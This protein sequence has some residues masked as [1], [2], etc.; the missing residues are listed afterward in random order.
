ML[1][2]RVPVFARQVSSH[3]LTTQRLVRNFCAAPASG[4]APGVKEPDP[5][6][7]FDC[8]QINSHS[9]RLAGN[10]F[11]VAEVNELHHDDVLDSLYAINEA[12]EEDE[13]LALYLQDTSNKLADKQE[14]LNELYLQLEEDNEEC[15]IDEIAEDM[16]DLLIE[17]KEIHLLP[18]IVEDYGRIV[19]D[20]NDEVVATVN[21]AEPLTEQQESQVYAK[22]SEISTGKTVLM[23]TEV[24]PSLLGGMTITLGDQFQDL[25]VRAAL[26]AAE[27]ALRAQ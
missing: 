7:L 24:D 5:Q 27:S 21:T 19:L 6:E 8:L 9:G 16:V 1:G 23:N 26:T 22:L 15:Y 17:N 10:L 13:L 25:S 18:E 11:Q 3:L 12:I 14:T 2:C 4:L 20:Y